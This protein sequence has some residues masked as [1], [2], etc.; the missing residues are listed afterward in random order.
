M[1]ILV[2]HRLNGVIAVSDRIIKQHVWRYNDW[3]DPKDPISNYLIFIFKYHKL[4]M[5]AF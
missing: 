5:I 2:S 1:V 4:L 3:D